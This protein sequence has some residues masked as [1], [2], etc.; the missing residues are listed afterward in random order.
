MQR[1]LPHSSAFSQWF[2]RDSAAL[3]T[4]VPPTHEETDAIRNEQFGEKSGPQSRCFSFSGSYAEPESESQEHGP[5]HFILG[6]VFS[7][8]GRKAGF[9]PA[10]HSL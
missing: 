10:T 9:E 2:P 4:L 5:V 8:V 3:D 6:A 7:S 1:F